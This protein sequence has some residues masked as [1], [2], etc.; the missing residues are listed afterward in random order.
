[1]RFGNRKG[2][3]IIIIIKCVLQIGKLIYL[4]VIFPLFI[5]LYTSKMIS[6]T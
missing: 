5:S 2:P 6:R 4:I 1:M 3:K